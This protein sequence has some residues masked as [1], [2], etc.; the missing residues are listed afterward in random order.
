MFQPFRKTNV[1]LRGL[2]GLQVS[3][4]ISVVDSSSDAGI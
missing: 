1:P 2:Q 4:V 3:M